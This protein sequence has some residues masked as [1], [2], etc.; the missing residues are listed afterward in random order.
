MENIYIFLILIIIIFYCIL[1]ND[2]QK[3]NQENFDSSLVPVS[4][5]VTLANVA[6]KLING[7]EK[8]INPGN[9]QIG[10]PSSVSLGN[11]Y[12]TGTNNVDGISTFNSSNTINGTTTFVGNNTI[13]GSSVISG[14]LTAN[15][16]TSNQ[17]NDSSNIPRIQLFTDGVNYYNS[18]FGNLHHFRGNGG[19]AA[20]GNVLIDQDLTVD[21]NFIVNG[22]NV[23]VIP[24]SLFSVLNFLLYCFSKSILYCSIVLPSLKKV[25]PTK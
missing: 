8:L 22:G 16:I 25:I 23:L 21:G 4:S 3:Y 15:T 17:Y 6:Q 1:S 5:V 7:G 11:L 19:N 9:L 18:G 20:G 2:H 13:S 24:R 14:N 10:L 12:V